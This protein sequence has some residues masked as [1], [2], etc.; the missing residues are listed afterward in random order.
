MDDK[1]LYD[2]LSMLD[3]LEDLRE[4]LEELALNGR[5]VA[6]A[7]DDLRQEIDLLGI[8]DLDDVDRRIAELNAQVDRLGGREGAEG[9][10]QEPEE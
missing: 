1:E 2:L 10:D 4:D 3:R 8:R 6:D 9:L 7:D 5:G